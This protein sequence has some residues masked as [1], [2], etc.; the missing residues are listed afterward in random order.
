MVLKSKMGS[1]VPGKKKSKPK[2]SELLCPAE[3]VLFGYSNSSQGRQRPPAKRAEQDAEIR[4][5]YFKPT[6]LHRFQSPPACSLSPDPPKAK[7]I[8]FL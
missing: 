8:A 7:M 3:E 6:A 2:S 5:T 1:I 4:V